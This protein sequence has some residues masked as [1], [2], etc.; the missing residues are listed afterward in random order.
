MVKLLN[1]SLAVVMNWMSASKMNFNPDK[2]G[3]HCLSAPRTEIESA[4]DRTAMDQIH[5]LGMILNP[6]LTLWACG[7]SGMKHLYQF[8]LVLQFRYR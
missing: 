8:L 3:M 1:Q 5:G 6:P 2:T 4:L 7:L